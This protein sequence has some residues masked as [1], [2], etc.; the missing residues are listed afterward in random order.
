MFYKPK[1][2]CHC[3]DAIERVHWRLRDSRR[4]CDICETDHVIDDWSGV[5]ACLVFIITF[6]IFYPGE[7]SH[8]S[9]KPRGSPVKASGPQH[10]NK[11]NE[12]PSNSSSDISFEAI[13][14]EPSTKSIERRP[15][16][17]PKLDSFCAAITKK[18]TPCTRK[19]RKGEK[20]WQHK[21]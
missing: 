14:S 10:S 13:E 7:K 6:F 17:R 8:Q 16:T 12:G 4:F 11:E 2:C 18:G 21:E 5:I 20:C 19:V 3:G 9:F 15:P 1:F